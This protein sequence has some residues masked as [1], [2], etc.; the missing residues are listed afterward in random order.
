[1]SH[2]SSKLVISDL[3]LPTTNARPFE[4]LMDIQMLAFGG[5]ERTEGQWRELLEGEEEEGGGRVGLKVVEFVKPEEGAVVSECLIVCILAGEDEG[6][7]KE[8]VRE[9]L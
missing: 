1:M 8:G 5:M 7:G 6:E 2:P 4:T 3:L 9:R